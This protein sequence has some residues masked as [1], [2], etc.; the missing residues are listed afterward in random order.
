M[1]GGVFFCVFVSG[2]LSDNLLGSKVG[3][4][5]VALIWRNTTEWGTTIFEHVDGCLVVGL[6]V[7]GEVRVHFSG[8]DFTGSAG[9]VW[10]VGP[11][12]G[13]RASRGQLALESAGIQGWYTSGTVWPEV[14]GTV[15]GSRVVAFG[16]DA[17]GSANGNTE[18]EELG[19][20]LSLNKLG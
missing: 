8:A 20:G 13:A 16:G 4:G 15:E 5:G 2:F 19:L 1:F 17:T 14:A 18:W 7:H 12:H 10:K 3:I 11:V 6:V 9:V